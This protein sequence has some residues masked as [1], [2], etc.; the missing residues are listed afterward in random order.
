MLV[1]VSPA[2][3]LNKNLDLSKHL[4]LK[5]TQPQFKAELEKLVALM[6]KFAP[7]QLAQLQATSDKIAELN[8]IR[9]QSWGQDFSIKNSLP[10]A[11]A[12]AG[13][14]FQNLNAFNM[15]LEELKI[16][17]NK[18]RILSGLYGILRPLD[19]MQNYRLEMGTKLS[20]ESYKNLYEFWDDK[21]TNNL[22]EELK[23]HSNK[24]IIN[25]ASNEYF[26]VVTKIK[27][28]FK[29]VNIEF[30]QLKAGKFKTIVIYTKMARGKMAQYI[31][32]NQLNNPDELKLFNWDSY[33]FNP[34]LSDSLNWTFTREHP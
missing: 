4:D 9:W 16:A 19:L 27:K 13:P 1:L 34:Q 2:K 6:Q 17:Q 11:L 30:K 20:F 5:Y 25:L 18:L 24:S 23:S 33:E 10:A 8:F 14:V 21:L 31:I 3:N 22:I 12:F 28:Q 26:K 7:H 32:K 15:N 29:T